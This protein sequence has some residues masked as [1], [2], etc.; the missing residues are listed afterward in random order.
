[1]KKLRVAPRPNLPQSSDLPTA[2][3]YVLALVADGARLKEAS[4]E[5]AEETGLSK[6]ELYEAALRAKA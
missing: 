1:M 6:R 4:T 2:V 5:V 3:A